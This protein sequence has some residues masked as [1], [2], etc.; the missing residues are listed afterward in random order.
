MSLTFRV[1]RNPSTRSLGTRDTPS[2]T[3]LAPLNPRAKVEEHCRSQLPLRL[4]ISNRLARRRLVRQHWP[5]YKTVNRA[6]T[7]NLRESDNPSL[8]PPRARDAIV[9][10]SHRH[11]E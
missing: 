2:K 5:L 10:V 4:R 1:A 3:C 11:M 8:E 9:L 7:P 6:R